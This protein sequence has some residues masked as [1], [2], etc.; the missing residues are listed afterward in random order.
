MGHVVISC[1]CKQQR[2]VAWKCPSSAHV[3]TACKMLPAALLLGLKGLVVLPLLF[4][5]VQEQLAPLTGAEAGR[6]HVVLLR[7]NISMQPLFSMPGSANSTGSSSNSSK[8]AVEAAAFVP[9]GVPLAGIP[10][11]APLSIV[12]GL[13]SDADAES[14]NTVLDLA[15]A[16]G[17]LDVT[18]DNSNQV[19][20]Q[21]Q[22]VRLRG[23]A[24][25]PGAAAATSLQSPDVW[26][27]L[28]W[29]FRR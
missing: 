15:F 27:L 4:C 8:A 13:S 26:T 23:L 17:L 12:G 6:P 5:A 18:E 21:V 22:H 9:P 19:Q 1:G 28:G 25:G 14:A 7:N 24:Q 16:R 10:V 20:L 11:P 2:F 29:A 3:R